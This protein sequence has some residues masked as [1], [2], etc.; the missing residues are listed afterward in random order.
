[1]E[2]VGETRRQAGHQVE[3]LEQ[4][5]ETVRR[6]VRAKLDKLERNLR[7]Q[8]FAALPGGDYLLAG[9]PLALRG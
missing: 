9:H 2:K 8:T 5:G 3:T 7:H 4:V 6:K 1:M